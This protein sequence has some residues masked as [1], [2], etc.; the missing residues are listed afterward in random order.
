MAINNR[1]R[2]GAI[3]LICA[4]LGITY[5]LSMGSILVRTDEL[6]KSDGIVVLMGSIPDRILQAV[7]LY[8]EGYGE[9]I[10]MVETYKRGYELLEKKNIDDIP[11]NEK[12]NE[13]IAIKMGVPEEDIIIIEGNTDSTQDKAIRVRDYLRENLNIS[14]LILVTSK[15]HSFRATKI[16]EKAFNK[17]DNKVE[18]IS[19]PTKY[20]EFDEKNWYKDREQIETVIFETIKL[21]NFYLREQFQL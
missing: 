18:V 7:E 8:K 17:L 20:D 3:F 19:C 15:S 6:K 13:L 21:M 1:K 10:I 9:K 2:F 11:L 5:L 12:L 4:L 14:S 16:F